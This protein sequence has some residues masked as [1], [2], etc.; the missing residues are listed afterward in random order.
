MALSHVMVRDT[1]PLT[2]TPDTQQ[3]LTVLEIDEPLLLDVLAG[4]GLS[5]CDCFGGIIFPLSCE[6]VVELA[7]R[8]KST[9]RSAPIGSL[10]DSFITS[11]RGL[12]IG[13]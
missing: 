7:A 12:D 11:P 10:R 6:P 8:G 9:P 13:D 1:I 4:R 5:G 3:L 2:R